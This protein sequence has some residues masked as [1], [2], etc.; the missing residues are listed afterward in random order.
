[1][2]DSTNMKV[3]IVPITEISKHDIA[4][5]RH[6]DQSLIT[7]VLLCTDF[8]VYTDKGWFGKEHIIEVLKITNNRSN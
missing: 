6:N 2:I 4:M 5:I 7:K 1:M 3:E 8:Q